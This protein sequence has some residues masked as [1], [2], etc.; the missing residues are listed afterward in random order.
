VNTSES[1]SVSRFQRLVARVARWWP[2]PAQEVP[3]ERPPRSKAPRG[4]L[5][6]WWSSSQL[7]PLPLS[8][9]DVGRDEH[10]SR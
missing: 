10:W 7:H 9:E 8:F 6:I 3:I 1:L 4:R 5:L 2:Q